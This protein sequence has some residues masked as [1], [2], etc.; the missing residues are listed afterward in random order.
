MQREG[1]GNCEVGWELLIE[2]RRML[3]EERKVGGGLVMRPQGSECGGRAGPPV[4]GL[5]TAIIQLS[6]GPGGDSRL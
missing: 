1:S 4:S 2:V 6:E 3:D 5:G